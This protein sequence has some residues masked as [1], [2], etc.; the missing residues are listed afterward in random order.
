MKI[1]TP[2]PENIQAAAEVLRAG[3]LVAVPTETVYGLAANASD[4]DAI[5]KIYD[6]KG[7][8][9]NN[10]LIVHVANTEMAEHYGVMNDHAR[11]LASV[12][13][14]GPLTIV[15]PKSNEGRMVDDAAANL[16]TVAIRVPA[17]PVAQDLLLAFDGALAMP[18]AN[19]SGK[20]SPTQANHV[21][22]AFSGFDQ[23]KI[24]LAGGRAETGL[25]STI[26]DCLGNTPRI[27]RP[28]G[29]TLE[30]L[31]N[32]VPETQAFIACEID[33]QNAE[34]AKPIAPGMLH[35]HYAP[36]T[37]LRLNAAEVFEGEAILAF[38][39]EP[40]WTRR[41]VQMLN[42][43]PS[44][45]LADAAHNL[46]SHLHML[47]HVGA[48]RIAVMPIPNE[49]IGIAINDRLMRGAR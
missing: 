33:M 13:W 12:F 16:D 24:I 1:L 19:R 38:G 39:K 40:L 31:Q 2:T 27:L 22:D 17:H 10:P 46:F 29:I 8:P 21:A 14:P 9:K 45:D 49:G 30:Q 43:S 35:Q 3:D 47:D 15:M 18:S 6:T 32:V 41:G 20:L 26:V 11:A 48:K 34:N 23:P 4:A 5:Q 36:Q 25:E 37:P 7:R 44:G 28:G 42:L